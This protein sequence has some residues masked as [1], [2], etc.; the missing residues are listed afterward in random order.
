MDYFL[1]VEHIDFALDQLAGIPQGQYY[2]DMAVAWA[3][4]VALIKHYDRTEPLFRTPV[5]SKFVHNKAI[6]KARESFRID[7]ERKAYLNTLKI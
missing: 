6:Q 7:H 5:F 2:V 1:D 3:L 4:S